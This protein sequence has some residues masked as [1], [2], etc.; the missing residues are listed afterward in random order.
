MNPIG[1]GCAEIE[2]ALNPSGKLLWRSFDARSGRVIEVPM[3]P[4]TTRSWVGAP[5][6]RP[7]VAGV[8]VSRPQDQ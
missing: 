4:R 6:R 5:H 3:D 2:D 1:L 8:Y 7:K